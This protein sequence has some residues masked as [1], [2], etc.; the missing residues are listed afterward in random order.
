MGA[1]LFDG[2]MVG[3]S[4]LD[5]D[6]FWAGVGDERGE[7]WQMSLD[8]MAADNAVEGASRWS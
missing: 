1:Y 8:S 3:Y 2:E 7:V 6:D 5:G 4:T